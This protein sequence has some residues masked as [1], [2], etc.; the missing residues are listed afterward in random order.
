MMN[1][2]KTAIVTIIISII[3][4]LLVERFKSFGPRILCNVG[5]RI[6]VK[7]NNKMVYAYVITVSNLSKK[8]IHRLTLNI[9]S[10]KC[11]L[12]IADAKITKGL[13]FESSAKDNSLD[14]DI[15]FLSRRDKFSVTVYVENQYGVYNKPS[16]VIRSPEN[17]KKIDSEE[18]SGVLT[19]LFNIRK[20][21][22]KP[23]SNMDKPWQAEKTINRESAQ[24]P[25]GNNKLR[26][27]KKIIMI[28]ASVL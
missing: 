15:P 18:K 26:K 17:F 14:I 19:S 23:I 27:N 24:G 2:I 5:E 22:S 3:S 7:V 12:K 11:S 21:E 13:K 20:N 16:V 8:I 28:A 10:P 6:S 25:Q 4:G 9:Q 1:V